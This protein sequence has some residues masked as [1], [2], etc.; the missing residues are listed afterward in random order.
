MTPFTVPGGIRVSEDAFYSDGFWRRY[1]SQ[2]FRLVSVF[3]KWVEPAFA[4]TLAGRKTR[5]EPERQRRSAT[6]GA[7]EN[8]PRQ[9]PWEG[10]DER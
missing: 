1:G 2:P 3:A 6:G 4:G 10:L 7:K 5:S 9:Q 8:L